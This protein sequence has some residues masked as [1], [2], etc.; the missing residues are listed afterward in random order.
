MSRDLAE[1]LSG[2]HLIIKSYNDDDGEEYERYLI[3]LLYMAWSVMSALAAADSK[4][5]YSTWGSCWPGGGD[6]HCGRA[7]W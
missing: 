3:C 4:A 5:A 2:A 6:T 7:P 1:P